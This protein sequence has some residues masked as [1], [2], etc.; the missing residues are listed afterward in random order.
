MLPLILNR[1][2]SAES[3]TLKGHPKDIINQDVS[4]IITDRQLTTIDNKDIALQIGTEEIKPEYV[5]NFRLKPFL[6][7]KSSK[8]K[9]KNKIYI[10][11]DE[12]HEENSNT[13]N[14][15]EEMVLKNE[16]NYLIKLRRMDLANKIKRISL[17]DTSAGYDILSFDSDGNKKLIE[18]KSTVLPKR[19]EFS[20]NIT[21][22]EKKVAESS[23]NYFIYLV[24]DVN[25]Q[26]PKIATI[27]N[28]FSL[29]MLIVEPTQYIV[30]GNTG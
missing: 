8:A 5:S 25:G 29:G 26:S 23:D 10:D 24:F 11:F 3:D 30:R 17:E 19:K 2:S 6:I 18:V 27:K 21:S 7:I 20:F 28:P 9:S 16:K 12:R 14:K 22:N 1:L 13:G 4:S 15:G